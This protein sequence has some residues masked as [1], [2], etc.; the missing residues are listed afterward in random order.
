[1]KV[2]HEKIP[3]RRR[4]VVPLEVIVHLFLQPPLTWTCSSKNFSKYVVS[5]IYFIFLNICAFCLS[6]R[7]NTD[8]QDIISIS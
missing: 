1:M 6:P 2:Q 5:T 7:V 3:A 4:E 8:I